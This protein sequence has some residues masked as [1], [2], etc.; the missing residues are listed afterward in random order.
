MNPLLAALSEE[1]R[2]Q[3]EK[4]GMPAWTQPMLATLTDE[5][6]SS[7]D[8]LFERKLDGERCLVFRDGRSARLFS[9]NRERLDDTYPELAEALERQPE[10]RFIVDGE[11]VAFSGGTTSFARL[12]DRMRITDPNEARR[13]NVRVYFYVFDL[14]HLDGYDTTG[15]AL[16]T[17][18]ALLREL[19]D[20][21]GPL[22]YTAH[23]NT[24]G[25]R[26]YEAACDKGWEGVIAKKAD[27]P[28]VH[29]RSRNWLKFKCVHEQELVIAGY[30]DPQG[31]R[32]AFGALLLGY[33][34][35]D[36]LRYAGKVGT[37]FDEKT[38]KELGKQ[39]VDR[40]R[41]DCPFA[42]GDE[43][44]GKGVHWVDPELVAQIGFTEWTE[45]HRLRHPRYLGLRR[46]KQ[47]REVVRETP[48]ASRS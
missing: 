8:W 2:D 27:S 39:L 13:S 37:G 26:Y 30:T 9:R 31:E 41:D 19:L 23:R 20:F 7:E 17:R 18:K 48:G 35:D 14:L 29:S 11:I 38:L 21:D 4:T 43:I 24:E 10:A 5:R 32:E 46:D 40:E 12:Q 33:Y 42:D 16:R 47:P 44:G 6:F 34:E 45:D 36:A 3:L 28:Y 25:E 1:E 15:L 22:R